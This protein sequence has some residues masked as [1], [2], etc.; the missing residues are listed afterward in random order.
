MHVGRLSD[1]L[2]NLNSSIR[3]VESILAE[4]RAEHDPLAAYIFTAR[5]RYRNT[6]DTKSGKSKD[7]SAMLS[8]Q[9]ACEL[10]F[11]GTLN[12]WERLM[13]AAVKR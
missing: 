9:R 8:W 2:R 4:M 3:E 11:C 1:A 13:G 10:G 12:E 6:H 7:R 5:R